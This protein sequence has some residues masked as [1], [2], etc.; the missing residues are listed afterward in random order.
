LQATD[1]SSPHDQQ[2]GEAM[3]IDTG[4]YVL[5]VPSGEKWV[6]ACVRGEYLSWMGWPEGMAKLADCELIEKATPESKARLLHEL[7]DNKTNDHRSRF[8][9][10]MLAELQEA[11]DE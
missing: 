11:R 9:R 10:H 2:E 8:A 4:D 5:H 3:N 1:P 6:V 7:A